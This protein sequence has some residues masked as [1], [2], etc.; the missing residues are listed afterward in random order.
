[1]R[2]VAISLL[3]LAVFA[4]GADAQTLYRWV[5]KNG[6]VT[7]SDQPPPKE[8]KQVE[9]P[10]LRSST[11]ETSGAGYETQKAAQN[12]PVTLYTTP[13]CVSECANARDLLT[14]RGIPFSE[15]RVV[16]TQDGDSFKKTLGTDKLLFPAMTMGSQKQIG[17]EADIWHGLLDSAGY[18]R[19][20]I[21]QAA[22]PT[23]SAPAPVAK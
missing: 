9:Q 3:S 6:K 18:P 11:I 16:T 20:A 2:I 22:P 17:F 8:I 1:M 15:N 19:T 10:R 7:Y 21:S 4:T 14:R 23:S 12:F 5:D 13:D